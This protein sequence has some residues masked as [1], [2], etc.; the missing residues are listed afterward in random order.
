MEKVSQYKDTLSLMLICKPVYLWNLLT[1]PKL[2][3]S[4]RHYGLTSQLQKDINY[5]DVLP[6]CMDRGGVFSGHWSQQY[7][8]SKDQTW[9]DLKFIING[10]KKAKTWCTHK[11]NQCLFDVLMLGHSV[12]WKTPT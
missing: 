3:F 1:E 11:S 5:Y 6:Q 2:V 4:R 9:S 10:F 7:T 12:F 8:G